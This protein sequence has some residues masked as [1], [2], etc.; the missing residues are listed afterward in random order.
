MADTGWRSAK[1]FAVAV[2]WAGAAT[3]TT[4][5]RA[6]SSA[7]WFGVTSFAF[8]GVGAAD[9]VDAPAAASSAAAATA[10]AAVGR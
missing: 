7:A 4:A 3:V 2:V 9:A 1:S 6:S 8:A 10:P 5:E